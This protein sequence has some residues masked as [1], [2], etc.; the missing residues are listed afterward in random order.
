MEFEAQKH[1][2]ARSENSTGVIQQSTEFKFFG[3]ICYAFLLMLYQYVCRDVIR[4]YKAHYDVR[5]EMRNVVLPLS[6]LTAHALF[7]E[8]LDKDEIAATLSL[9]Y[10]QIF[11]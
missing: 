10:F 4:Y 6:Y 2:V 7:R 3:L 1:F 9:I 11:P 8:E 5:L